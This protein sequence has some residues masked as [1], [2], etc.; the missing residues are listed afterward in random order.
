MKEIVGAS[1]VIAA[2]G[3]C[4]GEVIG[5]LGGLDKWFPL[6]SACR[7]EGSGAGAR[8][9]YTLPNGA[10]VQERIDEVDRNQM[11]VRYSI[12]K[13]ALPVDGYVGTVVVK[14][15]DDAHSE[16]AWH[17][18]YSPAPEHAAEL[19]EMLRGA[20]AEGINGLEAYCNTRAA[21]TGA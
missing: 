16:I 5:S 8:R 18:E 1:A 9:F 13:A 7:L 6:V 21:K 15:V 10:E 20:I 19:R 3:S 12:T 17:A 11:R 2:P 4:A 14:A